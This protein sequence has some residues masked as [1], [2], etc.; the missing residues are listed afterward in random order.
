MTVT[1]A[2]VLAIACFVMYL[3]RRRTR[4]SADDE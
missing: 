1:I 3:M 2:T 4:L